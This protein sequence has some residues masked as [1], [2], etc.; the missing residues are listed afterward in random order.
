MAAWL[1]QTVPTLRHT[2]EVNVSCRIQR[3]IDRRWR[4]ARHPTEYITRSWS[5]AR[6]GC[7]T[8][9]GEK[10]IPTLYVPLRKP[11]RERERTPTNN[12]ISPVSW[13]AIQIPPGCRQAGGPAWPTRRPPTSTR[14]ASRS[15]STTSRRAS[16]STTT[17]FRRHAA[18]PSVITHVIIAFVPHDATIHPHRTC[19]PQLS[20]VVVLCL[21]LNPAACLVTDPCSSLSH[22]YFSNSVVLHVHKSCVCL[23]HHGHLLEPVQVHMSIHHHLVLA[24]DG[25]RRSFI[26]GNLHR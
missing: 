22:V 1:L 8:A 4:D 3:Q 5:V 14:R 21:I 7:R 23:L 18:M 16:K 6:E 15:A 13:L 17:F 2:L 20:R 24:Y 19:V 9:V 25:R 10:G 11:E 12:G 26:A